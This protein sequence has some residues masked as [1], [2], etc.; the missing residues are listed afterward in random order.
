[1]PPLPSP[2]CHCSRNGS[3]HSFVGSGA[4]EPCPP[5]TASSS[6][7]LASDGECPDC[8]PGFYCPNW[9][10]S[11]ATLECTEGFYCPGGDANATEYVLNASSCLDRVHEGT[12]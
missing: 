12:T 2:F 10:T 3:V 5:G 11:N 6:F 8:T 4:P 1:M 7:A 9:G